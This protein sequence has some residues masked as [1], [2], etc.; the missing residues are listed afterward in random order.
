M[1][2]D[3]TT[4][5]ETTLIRLSERSDA[6]I[7]AGL[8][9]LGVARCA[10]ALLRETADR[11]R[12][13]PEPAAKTPVAVRL[14]LGEEQSAYTITLGGGTG[15]VAQGADEAVRARLTQDLVEFLRAVYGTPGRHDATRELLV[16]EPDRPV[17]DPADPD[18]AERAAAV[19]ALY[20]LVG[21][22]SRPHRSLNELAVRFR[23]DKWGGHWYTPHYDR[24]FAPLRDQAVN[25]LEIGIGGYDDPDQ[26]GAS[27]RMWK[28]YFPRG[29]VHGLDV[30][31]KRGIAEPRLEPL[32]GDQSD[33]SYLAALALEKGPFDIV[34]DDG[35]HLNDHVLT[36]FRAL[37]PHVRPGGLYVIEDTQT[38]YWP[39]WGGNERDLNDPAT[40]MGFVKAL[41][42]GLNHQERTPV[43]DAGPSPAAHWE[44]SIGAVHVHHNLVVVEKS[45]NTEQGAPSWVPRDVDP[46]S[47]YT[48]PER[49]E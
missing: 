23:S 36:S 38:A 29:T 47:W 1:P 6:D 45:V 18:H 15:E 46:R 44:R 3:A 12:L 25:L 26:G 7:A 32:L 42:D 33:A 39:G 8:A 28:H 41:V 5:L 20:Q 2:T 10:E 48:A 17:L 43:G 9:E 22:L 34:I 24:Y 27:L 14:R 21:A 49:G 11:A 19:T 37:F 31:E 4:A 35:S 16:T 13:F 30:H 40:S